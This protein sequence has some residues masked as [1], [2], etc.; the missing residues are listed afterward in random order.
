MNH[1]LLPTHFEELRKR[2]SV[3]L[4]VEERAVEVGHVLIRAMATLSLMYDFSERVAN[5]FWKNRKYTG[6][7]VFAVIVISAMLW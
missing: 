7:M 1:G 5:F 6:K 2:N 3:R 4:F